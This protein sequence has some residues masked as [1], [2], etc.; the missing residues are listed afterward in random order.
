MNEVL[1]DIVLYVRNG[2]DGTQGAPRHMSGGSGDARH[3]PMA[4][5]KAS[6]EGPWGFLAVPGLSLGSPRGAQRPRGTPRGATHF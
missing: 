6:K 2:D 5:T 4:P 1:V 3:R